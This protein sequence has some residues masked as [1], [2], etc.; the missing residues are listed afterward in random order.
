VEFLRKAWNLARAPFRAL[1][2]SISELPWDFGGSRR[3]NVADAIRLIPLFACVRILSEQISSLPMVAYRQTK[4][5][6]LKRIK[7][8]APELLVRPSSRE[9]QST[10]VKK[11]VISLA[12]RGNAYGYVLEFDNLRRP[13]RIEWLNP[14][15]IHVE[16]IDIANGKYAPTYYY[17]GREIPLDR[18]RHIVWFPQPGSALGLS[19]VANFAQSIGVGLRATEFGESWFRNGGTPPGTFKNT[20]RVLTPSQTAEVA[21]RL[22]NAI[23]R[24]KTLV[25]GTDWEFNALQVNPE[26]SQFIE[27]MKLNATQIAAIYGVPPEM[28]GGETGGSLTYA[29]KAGDGL[30]LYK[31]TVRPWLVEIEQ[32]ISACLQD[33]EAMRF[34]ADAITRADIGTRYQAYNVGITSGF[35]TPNEVRQEEG[36]EPLPGGDEIQKPQAPTGRPKTNQD[37]EDKPSE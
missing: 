11:L 4:T 6:E 33:N 15:E 9:T 19:P 37:D 12:L 25:Y 8:G 22:D 26:E 29:T 34:D 27:T 21:D 28:V 16:D 13:K 5:G 36:L 3:E 14:D 24:R 1:A 32:S 7:R 18:M 31:F 30:A 23:R 2:R 10:W 17:A 20:S 35:L